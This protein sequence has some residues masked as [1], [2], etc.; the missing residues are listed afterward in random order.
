MIET[1]IVM[2][3][4]LCLTGLFAWSFH[5]LPGEK[6][7]ILAT[8]PTQRD[9][10]GAWRGIN[11]TYYGF[12]NALGVAAAVAVTIFLAGAAG[13]PLILLTGVIVAVLAVC[14]PAS[15]IINRLVEGHWHGFTIGGASFAGMVV[16][17]WLA[18][19]IVQ[20]GQ[21]EAASSQATLFVLAAIATAYTLGEG[22]GRL[23]CISFGCCYGRPLANCP[24]WLQTLFRRW[25]FVFEGP[26]K[27]SS[28]EHGYEGQPLIPVQAVTAMISSAAGLTGIALFL[29][30]KPLLAY[31]LPIVITQLWRFASEFLR[32]D[33]RGTGRI[34]AYQWMALAGVVYTLAFSLLWPHTPQPVM[35]LTRG[36]A[37]LWSPSAILLIEALAVIVFVRMGISTVTSARITFDLT[38][39]KP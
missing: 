22:I 20:L 30:G 36:F 16:G 2:L 34:S 13:L 17:P 3:M 7:Q 15:K 24:S 32:A 38:R 21:K 10:S 1:L 25:S 11:L 31:V 8:F 26:L 5:H 39:K 9:K 6:W 37:M 12:F 4:A 29:A 18:W 14:I 19:G 35:D 27:K 33:Y 23:A 28:Y